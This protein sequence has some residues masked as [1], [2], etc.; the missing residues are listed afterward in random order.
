MKLCSFFT[1]NSIF[2]G[3]L[4]MSEDSGKKS[5]EQLEDLLSK[6][7]EMSRNEE[8]DLSQN[9]T[10]WQRKLANLFSPDQMKL[11]FRNNL[12]LEYGAGEAKQVYNDLVKSKRIPK[13]PASS[14]VQNMDWLHALLTNPTS[15]RFRKMSN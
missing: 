11:S 4:A 6:E 15:H 13:Y 5:I 12:I 14:Y 2:A 10:E 9:A 1:L 7:R 8:I 3:N